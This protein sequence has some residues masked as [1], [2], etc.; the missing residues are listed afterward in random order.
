[1]RPVGDFGTTGHSR[2]ARRLHETRHVIERAFLCKFLLDIS[3]YVSSERP[4][5]S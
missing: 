2:L 5:C 4:V 1:M 3:V